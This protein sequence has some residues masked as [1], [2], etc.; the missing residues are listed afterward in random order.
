MHQCDTS[1]K[2]VVFRSFRSF[3]VFMLVCVTYR[4][5]DLWIE[6]YH[7]TAVRNS[8][9]H[10]NEKY[11]IDIISPIW[12]IPELLALSYA[13]FTW[14]YIKGVFNSLILFYYLFGSIILLSVLSVS[15][16]LPQMWMNLD[17]DRAY[18][19]FNYIGSF[20]AVTLALLT[21]FIK[22]VRSVNFHE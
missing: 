4:V 12:F 8:C 14:I 17:G 3:F 19:T 15:Y 9:A 11:L 20:V 2:S 13:V 16:I 1:F 21:W 10:V 18:N 5:P 6:G 7:D 22:G